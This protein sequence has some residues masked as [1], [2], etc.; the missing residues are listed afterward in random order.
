M[1][2]FKK[3]G[4]KEEK[5]I[6]KDQ[7]A[8]TAL[9]AVKLPPGGDDFSYQVIKMP[10][11]SE[12]ASNVSAGGQ[13]IFKVFNNANKIEIKKAIERL[14]S[15]NVEKVNIV[16]I[17]SKKRQV[18]RFKGEKKGYKKAIVVL[19]KGQTIEAMLK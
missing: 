16:R 17:P 6:E 9:G 5:K 1:D 8:E 15:V 14:Y 18:G 10:H 2:L 3:R 13:Y 4:K 19:R 7:K 11:V 12:K